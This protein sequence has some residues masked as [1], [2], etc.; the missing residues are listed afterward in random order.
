MMLLYSLALA[1]VLLLTS[2]VWG[3]RMLR[4]GR[5]R[6]GLGER[7]GA[8]PAR[9][10]AFI[11]GRPVVWL[12][13]VSVGETVAATRLVAELEAALPGYAIVISTTTPTGQ[14]VARERFGV[15]RVFF[16]PLDFAFAVRAYLHV[17]KP[18]L[19]VLM[20]SE[21][22]PRTLAE[23]SR[24]NIPV[25][26]VNARVSDRSLPRYM[27][28]RMLWRPLLQKIA[29]LLAQSEE[30]AARWRQ[31]G[32]PVDRVVTAGNLK[33]DVRTPAET[34]LTSLLRKHLPADA[35]VL[36]CGSTHEGE[37][38]LL[39]DCWRGML[40][41]TPP[42]ERV[43]ILAPRH[44]Q[45]ADA[46]EQLAKDRGLAAIRLSRWRLVPVAITPDAV[47]IVDTVGELSSLYALAK[48]AYVGGSLVPHGGQNPL[49]PAQFGVPVVMG[50]SYENFRGIVDGMVRE[51]A[52]RMVTEHD[53]CDVLES[54]LYGPDHSMGMRGKTFA[55]SMM[56]ATARTTSALVALLQERAR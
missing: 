31:I 20:E 52:I 29:L 16:F 53:V 17:L 19:L 48:V 34:P 42:A 9:L 1:V 50:P 49:E 41:N 3:V 37:E 13:A 2:P 18:S 14:R 7:L 51:Q 24:A 46:V 39:L 45:R 54:L 28:L 55:A 36:I 5:Y 22:W 6:E 15:D 35:K 43:M 44:P 23:C 26:V 4:Q 11:Q 25:A 33:Y 10:A 21:L 32:A 38:T 12:H 47:L 8:V 30:D 40:P 56:G 27:A